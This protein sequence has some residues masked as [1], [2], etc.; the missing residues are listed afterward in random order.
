VNPPLTRIVVGMYDYAGLNVDSFQVTANFKVDDTAAGQN[1]ASKFRSVSPGVWELK[2]GAPVTVG[3]GKLTLSVK[4]R[5]GNETR[6]ER[7]FSAIEKP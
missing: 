3:S 2:L 6:I 1:L 7:T 4:D 5:Q